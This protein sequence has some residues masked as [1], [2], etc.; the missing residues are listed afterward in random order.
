MVEGKGAIEPNTD[1]L[2]QSLARCTEASCRDR[3]VGIYRTAHDDPPPP[4]DRGEL[5]RSAWGFLHTVAARFPDKPVIRQCIAF[6]FATTQLEPKLTHN[7]EA[8]YK[9]QSRPNISWSPTR[10]RYVSSPIAS[11]PRI[12]YDKKATLFIESSQ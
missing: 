3:P 11:S 9:M 4:P 6:N 8:S 2:P 5:G 1:G 7:A 10:I 12:E